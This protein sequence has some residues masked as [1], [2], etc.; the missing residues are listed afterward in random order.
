ML[1]SNNNWSDMTNCREVDNGWESF[2]TVFEPYLFNT[3]R[4]SILRKTLKRKWMTKGLLKSSNVKNKLY[5]TYKKYPSFLNKTN[6][7]RYENKLINLCRYAENLYYINEFEINK[8]NTKQTL[9][10]I[11]ECFG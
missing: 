2:L 3:C 7:T 11:K 1:L 10:L 8:N 4:P 6:Y 5:K 9:N